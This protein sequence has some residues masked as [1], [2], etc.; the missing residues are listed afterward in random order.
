MDTKTKVLLVWVAGLLA[1]GGCCEHDQT[2]WINPLNVQAQE[3]G[4]TWKVVDGDKLIADFGADQAGAEMA[5]DA[6]KHYRFTSMHRLGPN[7]EI[8]Y[9]TCLGWTP[10]GAFPG[11]VALPIQTENVAAVESPPGA[12]KVTDGV[13]SIANFGADKRCAE[14]AAMAIK[15]RGFRYQCFVGSA[16]PPPMMFFRR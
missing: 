16:A 7:S 10:M 12:W 9:F 1:V 2:L 4:G 15:L 6:I 14:S 11:V 5:R 8:M 13:R 3:I